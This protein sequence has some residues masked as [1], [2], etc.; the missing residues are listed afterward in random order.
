MG[1]RDLLDIEASARGLERARLELLGP[2]EALEA[3]DLDAVTPGEGDAGLEPLLEFLHR[4]RGLDFEGYKRASLARRIRRRMSMVGIETFEQYLDHL[5]VH[6]DEFPQLFNLILINV[7]G[8]F[9]LI[10][11]PGRR[12][13]IA[14]RRSSTSGGTSPSASGARAAPRERSPIP[15]R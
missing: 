4:S 8:F 1:G 2:E 13:R 12:S 7:T 3:V 6:P 5:E 9:R 14:W 11:A 10:P 15:S